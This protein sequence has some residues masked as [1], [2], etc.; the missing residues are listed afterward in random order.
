MVCF[1]IDIPQNPMQYDTE[2]FGK[3]KKILWQMLREIPGTALV[4]PVQMQGAVWTGEIF[5]VFVPC[6]HC[7]VVTAIL[8]T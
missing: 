7:W 6:P 4:F 8:R 1:C 5:M 2:K 3:M